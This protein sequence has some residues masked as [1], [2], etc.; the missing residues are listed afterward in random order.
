MQFAFESTPEEASAQTALY[1]RQ[2]DLNHD[3]FVDITEFNS[4][5]Y[6]SGPNAH[7][8]LIDFYDADGD[9]KLNKTE[10]FVAGSF[11]NGMRVKNPES[12]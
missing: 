7:V 10:F 8:V 9:K 12:L 5:K 6:L 1:F 11:F 3:G 4:Y 2:F